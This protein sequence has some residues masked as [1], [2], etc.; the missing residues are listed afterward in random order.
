MLYN[1]IR[2]IVEQEPMFYEKTYDDLHLFSYTYLNPDIYEQYPKAVE[3]RG[4][5]FDDSG[6]IVARPFPKFFNL[7]SSNCPVDKGR[8]TTTKKV[9]GSMVS[10]FK[11]DGEIRFSSKGAFRSWVVKDT[12]DIIPDNY[13]RLID[14]LT[15]RHTVV[16]ELIEPE[17]ANV[18]DYD[19][20]RLILT[21]IRR[22]SGEVLP[23]KE[24]RRFGET[25]G[26]DTVPVVHENEKISEIERDVSSWKG[27]EGV[28]G[29]QNGNLFKV[30]SPWYFDL[31]DI[32]VP[33]DE[34]TIRCKYLKGEIDT[35]LR[36]APSNKK[37]KIREIYRNAENRVEEKINDISSL[38]AEHNFSNRKE[39]ALYLQ[40]NKERPY[41]P[42]FR[43]W[44]GKPV[45]EVVIRYF[46]DKWAKGA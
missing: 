4:I 12:K 39:L 40:N 8:A 37:D 46:R 22:L 23:P 10:A 32:L 27:K 31:H 33:L 26:V 1:K 42:Y 11:Y 36:Q 20:D 43:V 45:R 18:I 29:Y 41:Y 2:D 6:N 3:A 15:P 24:V 35:I 44:E 16:F 13:I 34:D 14:K 30:K 17:E 7:G 25:Y 21:G 28:V 38:F 9:D 19:K 5:V